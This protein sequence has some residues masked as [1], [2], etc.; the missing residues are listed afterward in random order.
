MQTPRSPRPG[1]RRSSRTDRPRQARATHGRRCPWTRRCGTQPTR[2]TR[3]SG[4]DRAAGS[5]SAT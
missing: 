1:T 2:P 4:T 5:P 3:R